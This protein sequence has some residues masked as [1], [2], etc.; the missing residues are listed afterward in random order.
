MAD[1][2][3]AGLDY[4]I[5][6]SSQWEK[7]LD[8]FEARID[9]LEKRSKALTTSRT[10][11]RLR[12][13]LAVQKQITDELHRQNTLLSRKKKAV[14]N[15]GSQ[16]NKV[17]KNIK[18]TKA[19][20]DQLTQGIQGAEKGA[21]KLL[22]TFRRLVGV[23]ALFTLARKL[24]AFIASG[25]AEMS[26]YNAVL[27]DTRISLASLIA[28]VGQ[29][30]DETGEIVT[31]AEAIAAGLELADDQMMSLRKDALSTKATFEDLLFA[32]QV[33]LGPGLSAG[34]DL[35]KVEQIAVD[36]AKAADALQVPAN[37]LSEEI[38]STIQGTGTAKNTRLNVIIKNADI[39]RA[40]EAGNLFEFLTD[41]LSAFADASDL[42]AKSYSGLQARLKTV[43]SNLLAAGSVEYFD[44]LKTSL[45]ALVNALL[46]SESIISDGG[47]GFNTNVLSGIQDVSGGLKE[48]VASFDDLVEAENV[49][50]GLAVNMN[51]I[52]HMLTI[53]GDL[54]SP[55]VVGIGRAFT[56]VS[57]IVSILGGVKEF[58]VSLPVLRQI[59]TY[60][61]DA[62]SVIT[63]IIASLILWKIAVLSISHVYN[64]IKGLLFSIG[65]ISQLIEVV[66]LAWAVAVDAYNT[67]LS[68]TAGIVAFIQSLLA[69]WP[70][71]VGAVLVVIVAILARF[72]VFTKL[73]AKA[74]KWFKSLK[75]KM[76]ESVSE[77]DKMNHSVLA[78]SDSVK[79][80]ET[81]YD[82]L[83]KKID[84]IQGKLDVAKA[85]RGLSGIQKEVVKTLADV[86][87]GFDKQ[88]NDSKK[89]ISKYK[90]DLKS[91]SD[92]VKNTSASLGAD[93]MQGTNLVPNLGFG[94]EL[95]ISEMANL[96]KKL[97][98]SQ[99]KQDAHN[100]ANK[101]QIT[102]LN[103]QILNEEEAIKNAQ[104]RR[105][106][107][108]LLNIQIK[109][110]ETSAL[111]QDVEKLDYISKIVGNIQKLPLF[112]Q[113]KQ[114]AKMLAIDVEV[115]KSRVALAKYEE[116]LKK[117]K[118]S[119]ITNARAAARI[120]FTKAGKSADELDKK[121]VKFEE[122][123]KLEPDD[124]INPDDLI[125]EINR[126][127]EDEGIELLILPVISK[128]GKES[129][130]RALRDVSIGTVD[131]Q[132]VE[133]DKARY[134]GM[135][136]EVSRSIDQW[137][138]KIQ[139]PMEQLGA[140]LTDFLESF[141][142]EVGNTVVKMA[143]GEDVDVREVGIDL[144]ANALQQTVS[145]MVSNLIATLFGLHN[146]TAALL[147]NTAALLSNTAALGASSTASIVGG[148][149]GGPVMGMAS[150]GPA[151]PRPSYIDRRDTV[152]RWLDPSEWVIRGEAV[153]SLVNKYGSNIMSTIN[154]G[155]LPAVIS[156]NTRGVVRGM[157]EGGPV[158]SSSGYSP[159]NPIN[160][161]G[162][163][164]PITQVLP[165]IAADNKTMQ[166]LQTGGSR[167]FSRGV[168]SVRNLGDV[169]KSGN[170]R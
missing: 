37:Q 61:R 92:Q 69:F 57:S 114:Q 88:I 122:S 115:A 27:E 89:Q 60:L 149:K 31:G 7:S 104:A 41:R 138:S 126:I 120:D 16:Y 143:K 2:V 79:A 127:A 65:V 8:R 156:H 97:Q 30:V 55:I 12:Q 160:N 11:R 103:K 25:V 133:A 87:I 86:T 23:L 121:I 29:I 166:Q 26:R 6:V 125:T 109:K 3:Q 52:G 169:N 95:R 32:F 117:T 54:V 150:G 116:T 35:D 74:I 14:S 10:G 21:S 51:A 22:F 42:V 46:D 36:I 71:V 40:R 15:L 134:E 152:P 38:R 48:I 151:F 72:G 118:E 131:V 67:K 106:D 128:A 165:V 70:L 5:I 84:S 112:G 66:Q 153:R 144:L 145:N 43:T 105:L 124:I 9:Q 161:M 17:A 33:A 93:R 20:T 18:K 157:S 1:R 68:I 81:A 90:A 19:P 13:E 111:D 101:L 58:L 64:A 170:T 155:V 164:A 85:I 107:I 73:I 53:V 82:K 98:Q 39:E 28:S 159:R 130:E 34:F 113:E 141:S 94:T 167:A 137:A 91:L 44:Q 24:S 49:T 76:V 154:A 99:E 50:A 163:N 102:K 80:L 139:D 148:F 77:L 142:D 83:G 63:S 56:F 59:Y 100:K 135:F 162:N 146:N 132:Q 62:L 136:G 78:Q 75:Q 96:S 168:E 119:I 147:S 140:S 47:W 108:A 110:A 123:L 129:M 4:E 158:G 45:E